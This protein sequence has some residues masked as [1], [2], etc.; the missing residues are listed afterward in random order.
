MH[1]CQYIR[2]IYADT[3]YFE[4][5]SWLR[6]GNILTHILI[7]QQKLFFNLNYKIMKNVAKSAKSERSFDL[8]ISEISENEV[9]TSHELIHI[10]GGST[11][12]EAD[13]GSSAISRPKF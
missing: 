7:K 8:L 2:V 11:E 5:K 9:L 13:G 12:G 4:L 6:A 3:V 1:I 10:K